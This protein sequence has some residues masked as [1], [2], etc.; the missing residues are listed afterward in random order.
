M[1]FVVERIEHLDELGVVR[2]ALNLEHALKVCLVVVGVVSKLNG[3]LVAMEIE[4]VHLVQLPVLIQAMCLK[5]RLVELLHLRKQAVVLKGIVGLFG[6][7]AHP[8]MHKL[9][10]QAHHL[11]N[12]ADKIVGHLVAKTHTLAHVL[13]ERNRALLAPGT[14]ALFELHLVILLRV[15]ARCLTA[16]LHGGIGRFLAVANLAG[17]RAVFVARLQQGHNL[18]ARHTHVG[19]VI[20]RVRVD[21]GPAV[22]GVLGAVA[23]RDRQVHGYNARVVVDLVQLV[24]IAQVLGLIRGLSLF[25]LV[26]LFDLFGRGVF[27]HRTARKQ[28]RTG[29]RLKQATARHH[30]IGHQNLPN[31]C[32][33]R[34]LLS[35]QTHHVAHPYSD[36]PRS[37]AQHGRAPGQVR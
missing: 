22:V 27:L 10:A 8:Q 11:G 32:D 26:L 36:L 15:I 23:A 33:T 18:K 17:H 12:P 7:V 28:Q 34:E 19:I 13:V 21:L 29:S 31:A 16:H 6:L 37:I 30:P 1:R 9:R 25:N 24:L 35:A 14:L 5:R 20:H 3:V 2:I 4:V